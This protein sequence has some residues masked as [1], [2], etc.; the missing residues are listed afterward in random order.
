MNSNLK[1]LYQKFYLYGQHGA[2]IC[3]QFA[4]KAKN[5]CKQNKA[6]L[7]KITLPL[8][9]I[10]FGYCSCA[11]SQHVIAQ[12]VRMIF[13]LSEAIRQHYGDKPSYWGL[14]T[15]YVI[16]QNIAPQKM[17]KNDKLYLNGGM[18]VLVG[19][20]AEGTTVMPMAQ[21]FDIALPHL[22]KAQCMSYAE[23]V[24]SDDENLALISVSI[25][26]ESGAYTFEWGGENR[27]PIKKYAT[28]QFCQDKENTIVWSLK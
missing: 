15:D 8:L 26:S 11:Y 2:A 12:N 20:G 18:S 7:I 21:S 4:T 24:L 16:K 6:F 25:I 23:N 10:G 1:N 14:N 5:I 22:N 13:S 19:A 9:I 27:L 3:G 28:K 17:I